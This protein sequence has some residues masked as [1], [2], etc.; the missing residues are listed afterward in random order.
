[1]PRTRPAINH[2]VVLRTSSYLN[3]SGTVDQVAYYHV[4]VK[5]SA[6]VV[7]LCP[8]DTRGVPAAVTPHASD[9]PGAGYAVASGITSQT[10]ATAAL[11]AAI[12]TNE[13][14]DFSATGGDTIE[15]PT[16]PH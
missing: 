5:D 10:A 6:G 13:G 16:T 8:L 4:A 3:A 14:L 9:L 2:V 7:H 15:F 12:A 1:M 11:V